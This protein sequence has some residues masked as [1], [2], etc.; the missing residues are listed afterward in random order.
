MWQGLKGQKVQRI[1]SLLDLRFVC[2]DNGV[3]PY[4]SYPHGN[5]FL[6]ENHAAICHGFPGHMEM[7]GSCFLCQEGDRLC[8]YA[9]SY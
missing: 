6:P 9:A 1:Y 4:G 7:P 3:F 5:V 2:A 8:V